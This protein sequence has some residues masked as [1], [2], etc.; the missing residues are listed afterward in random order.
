MSQAQR[1]SKVKVHYTGKL[2]DGTTFD[3]SRGSEPLELTIGESGVIPGFEES[4]IGMT[5]GDSK[6]IRLEPADAYG[7]HQD[8]LVQQ[9]ERSQIPTELELEVGRQLQVT[10]ESTLR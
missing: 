8:Q 1:G 7:D 6:E 5:V 4:I 10:T 9:V 2:E 3:S